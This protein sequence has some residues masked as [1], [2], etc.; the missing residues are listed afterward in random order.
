MHRWG[1]WNFDSLYNWAMTLTYFEV[2]H[3]IYEHEIWVILFN[4]CKVLTFSWFFVYS[5]NKNSF[6]NLE[7]NE[8]RKISYWIHFFFNFLCLKCDSSTYLSYKIHFF[9]QIYVKFD[10]CFYVIMENKY[11]NSI[12]IK[13]FL[14]PWVMVSFRIWLFQIFVF[15]FSFL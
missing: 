12:K 3:I 5:G 6:E 9:Y 14:F 1:T 2:S 4:L 15:D 8:K 7:L 11:L 10:T 13:F